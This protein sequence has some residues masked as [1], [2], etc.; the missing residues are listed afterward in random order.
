MMQQYR[1]PFNSQ[2]GFLNLHECWLLTKV[3][4]HISYCIKGTSYFSKLCVY[5]RVTGR[6]LITTSGDVKNGKPR[7][8][9]LVHLCVE[10]IGE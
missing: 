1:K 4:K 6:Y 7:A 10:K 8:E 5:S 3:A 9:L 2:H